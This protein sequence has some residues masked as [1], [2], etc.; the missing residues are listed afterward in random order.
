[1]RHELVIEGPGF[2]LRPVTD[3]D[4]P[5]LLELRGDPELSRFLHPTPPVLSNQLS[6]LA[7]YYERAGDYYFVVERQRDGAAEGVVALY[8]LDE[9][10]SMAEWGR[11][12]LRR[13]SLAAVESAALVYRCAFDRLALARVYC[14]TVADNVRV[15]AFHDSCG[16]AERRVLPAHFELGGRV[17]DAIEHG[18]GRN[19]WRETVGPH[20]E[21]LA[22]RLA[23]RVADVQP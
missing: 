3:A 13:G 11:W 6:W 5:L 17:F 4:A 10:R 14:R 16:C 9:T 20:L 15:V 19:N 12:I 7:A 1:M 18:V 21:R 2:R 23:A 22:A 8:D